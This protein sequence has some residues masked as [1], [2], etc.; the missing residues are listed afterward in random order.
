M[1]EDRLLPRLIQGAAW[2]L[3]TGIA[4]SSVAYA[5]SKVH[6]YN[7]SDYISKPVLEAFTAQTQTQVLYDVF[8]SNEALEGKLLAGRSGDR[9]SVV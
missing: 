8:D 4:F 6:V 7:W 1:R 3:A 5:D 2:A 9:K